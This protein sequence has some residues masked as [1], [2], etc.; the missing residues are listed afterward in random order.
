MAGSVTMDK[1]PLAELREDMDAQ[2]E[3]LRVECRAFADGER[4]NTEALW[5]ALRDYWTAMNYV[6]NSTVGNPAP[7]DDLPF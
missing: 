3:A 5:C 2:K 7:E 1:K 6:A 4:Q